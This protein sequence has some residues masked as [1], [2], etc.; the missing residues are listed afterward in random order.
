MPIART[1]GTDERLLNWQGSLTAPE[2]AL[3][4][5]AAEARPQE[6]LHAPH[7]P[8]WGNLSLVP[9]VSKKTT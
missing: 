8:E 1:G 9:E 4:A 6:A 5:V 7:E 3:Y 2:G